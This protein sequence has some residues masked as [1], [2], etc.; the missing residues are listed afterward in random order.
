MVEG[1]PLIQQGEQVCNGCALG[2]HHRKPFPQATAYRATT[3]LE[4]VHGDLCGPVTPPTP[5][6]KLYFLLV[7]D[8]FSRYMWVELLKTKDQAFES[9]KKIQTAAEMESGLKLRAFRTDR[10]GEFNSGVFTVYCNAHGIKHNTTAPYT[11]QQNGVVERRNQS[12]VEMARCL[13]KSKQVP[14][15]FWGEAVMVAVYLL[16]R[17]PT[18]SL[19][20]VTPYEAWYGK[21]PSVRHLRTFGC[22]AYAKKVGPGVTKLEDRTVPGIFLGYEPCSK[23]YRVYDPVKKRLMISRD[24]IFDEKKSWTWGVSGTNA[25]AEDVQESE[26]AVFSWPEDVTVADPTIGGAADSDSAVSAAGA[27]GDSTGAAVPGSPVPPTPSLGTPS[28]MVGTPGTS[29]SGVQTQVQWATPPTGAEEDSEGVPL[30]YRTI[31]DL[32]DSTVPFQLEYSGLCLVA[33]EEP[34]SVEQALTESYWRDAMQAEMKAIEANRTWEVSELPRNHKAIGLKWVFKVKKDPE[35]N[36]V[37]YKARLVAKGYAQRHGVDFDEVFAP[38]ARIETVRVLLALAA[39]GGWEVHHMDV[40]SAFLNGDLSETVFVQQ[41]PGFIVGKGDKVLRLRKALYG[42]RQAPRAWNF[43]L[44]KELSALGF[45]RSKLDNAVYKRSSKDS[46]LIVGVYVD[47][48]IILGPKIEDIN[49]FKA[50]MKLKFNMSD[51]GLLSYY[52]GIEVKQGKGGITLSQAAY[53]VRILENTGMEHC[54]PSDT[55]MEPRFKLTKGRESEAMNVTAYRS[56]IGS[57]RYLVNTRPDLAY[58]VGVVSRYMEAPGIAHWAAVKRVLRYVKG[59]TGYGCSYERGA[60]LKPILLGFSDSDFAGDSEDRKS[61]TGVIYFLGSSLVT[62]TSQKQK[63][64]ALSSCE[65]EYVAA[66]AAACQGVW[67]SRLMADLLGTKETP[68]KLLMDNMSAIALSRNPV[69]HDRSK[70]ID[71]RYHFIRE[72]IEEGRVEVEHV[73]TAGQLADIF[74]K[75]LG[76]VKFVELRTALGVVD[77]QQLRG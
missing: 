36:I 15:C 24:V 70:H 30:R 54:N 62:W 71:T 68:V 33:A 66:A 8:D 43:K 19:N 76:R 50:E 46:L 27:A 38:V 21:K 51:L 13:L 72:C 61:T 60:E 26:E 31:P 20:N 48:L 63:I 57:L 12:V 35:G 2:K 5:G 73:G 44:D 23:A 40:K 37:K 10:G 74:T 75:P 28:S 9:F 18:K 3:G 64:V 29:A 42:L 77:V 25:D 59:T 34:N 6:G 56:I 7:V 55:P 65:A 22:V 1:I 67:L 17:A 39:H 14:G 49:Q 52:L 32:L 41:P 69:H 11:P 16:N 45:V 4:L 58:A 47:D 53:A